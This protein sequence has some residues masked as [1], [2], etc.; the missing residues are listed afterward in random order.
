MQIL[1]N[2]IWISCVLLVGIHQISQK[3]FT[4]NLG[5]VDNYLDPFLSIPILLGL[6]LQERQFL[7][8]K[9]F[10]T[11]KQTDYHFSILEIMLATIFFAVIF[12]E[13]FPKWSIYFTKD[14]WDYL[15]Y[16]SGAL[17]FYFFIN[18]SGRVQRNVGP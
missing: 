8:N 11:N 13:G 17:V 7:I 6:I 10:S 9:Y 16:F 3:V 5:F 15:A 18:K 14:Y 12:E 4:Y 2:K 1:R